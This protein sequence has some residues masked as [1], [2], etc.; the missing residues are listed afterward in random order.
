MGL[1]RGWAVA[2]SIKLLG[3][4][5]EGSGDSESQQQAMHL[6]LANVPHPLAQVGAR[7]AGLSAAAAGAEVEGRY[8]EAPVRNETL[9]NIGN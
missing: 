5:A 3:Q 9:G 2:G 8:K 1:D 6:T 4:V 7:H